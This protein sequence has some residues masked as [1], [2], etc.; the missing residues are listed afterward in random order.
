MFIG[1]LFYFASITSV[2]AF[3]LSLYGSVRNQTFST[4]T[5]LGL[6]APAIFILIIM[7]LNGTFSRKESLS[8]I[9]KKW[10]FKNNEDAKEYLNSNYSNIVFN[11]EQKDTLAKLLFFGWNIVDTKEKELTLER[12]SS[13]KTEKMIF[14]TVS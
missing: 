11:E 8:K 1:L 5:F 2:I 12:V 6:I 4:M 7:I 3:A 14:N 10:K 13:T 9:Q